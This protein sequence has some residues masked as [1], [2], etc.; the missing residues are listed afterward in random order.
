MTD[1]DVVQTYKKWWLGKKVKLEGQDYVFKV[2]DVKF[3]GPPSGVYGFVELKDE[4]GSWHTVCDFGHFKPRK[5][6]VE[7]VD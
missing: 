2:V 5:K 4:K 1:Y 3:H 7:V 6:D